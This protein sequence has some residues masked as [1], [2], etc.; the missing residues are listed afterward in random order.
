MTGLEIKFARMK[1]G[2]KAYEL[3]SKVGVN[4]DRI[5]K[6]ETGRLVPSKELLE[7]ILAAI[8]EAQG[9]KK[10]NNVEGL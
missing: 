7:R 2:I 3:A 10:G 1:A 4:A 8:E 5:S 6:I 9:T